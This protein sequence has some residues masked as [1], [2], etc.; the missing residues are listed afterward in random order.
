MKIKRVCEQVMRHTFLDI[1]KIT[2]LYAEITFGL[3]VIKIYKWFQKLI[4]KE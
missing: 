1:I 2:I 4:R 3:T